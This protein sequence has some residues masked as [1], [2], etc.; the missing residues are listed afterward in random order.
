MAFGRKTGSLKRLKE[1]LAKG[2]GNG[3]FIKYTPKNGSIN[4]R[5][6]QEPEEWVSYNEHYDLLLKASYPCSGEVDC[7]GCAGGERKSQRYLVNAVNL[8]DKDRVIP[9]QLPKDLAN[10]LVIK[11]EKWG[12]ITDRDMEISRSGEGLDTVYDFDASAPDK[13]NLA[14]YVPLDLL[15][16]LEDVYNSV[17]ADKADDDEADE[18]K[19][20]ATAARRGR[21]PSAAARA[22][23]KPEPEDD[24]DD[25]EAEEPVRRRPASRKP[26]VVDDDEDEDDEDED[27]KPAPRRR[28]AK[29]EPEPE[30]EDEDQEYDEDDLNA[31][32]LGQL[33][34]VA[35]DLDI[36]T[37]KV[38]RE[39]LIEMILDAATP[40]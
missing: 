11:Y 33:R 32:K 29:P 25:A 4:V 3:A 27:E 12:S 34:G 1:T 24:E 7:P 22:S 5:F 10:R 28:T 20:R 26:A 14:K 18:P 2:G 40:F 36:E 23:K 8:D 17:F 38:S 30:P 19:P 6:L 13:K 9:F 31:M 37:A 39:D 21:T 35:R 16:V 15:K